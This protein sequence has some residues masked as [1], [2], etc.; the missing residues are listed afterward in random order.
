MPSPGPIGGSPAGLPSH[1]TVDLPAAGASG[2]PHISEVSTQSNPQ[3]ALRIPASA[4]ANADPAAK[5]SP[6]G[7]WLIPHSQA[8]QARPAP[9]GLLAGQTVVVVFNP[10]ARDGRIAGEMPAVK[11]ELEKAGARVYFKETVAEPE[12]RIEGIRR[13]ID[14]R[15]RSGR[16]ITVVPYGGDGTIGDVARALGTMPGA[17]DY[18][19]LALVDKGTAADLAKQVGAP[20][21]PAQLAA[22]IAKAIPLKITGSK[23]AG[24]AGRGMVGLHTVS[25]GVGGDLFHLQAHNK[26]QNPD[27]PA[28]RGLRSFLRLAPYVLRSP[29]DRYGLSFKT[30]ITPS[31]GKPS[32]TFHAAEAMI[33]SSRFIGGVAGIPGAW[34]SPQLIFL[35]H[36]PRGHLVLG[37]LIA[38]GLATK[39]LGLNLTGPSSKL[40]TLGR[41][42][43]IHL[44]P[45]SQVQVS[46][47]LPNTP[48]WQKY[49]K[50][51]GSVAFLHGLLRR[52]HGD[53][54]VMHEATPGKKFPL[55]MVVNG[56]LVNTQEARYEVEI[57]KGGRI[58]VLAHPRSLAIDTSANSLVLQ[59]NDAAEIV[60]TRLFDASQLN[61]LLRRHGIT[62]EKV[63][64]L[65]LAV[66]GERSRGQSWAR[67]S[68]SPPGYQDVQAFLEGKNPQG[69]VW[70]GHHESW[71]RHH[72]SYRKAFVERARMHGVPLLLGF[73]SYWAAEAGLKHLGIDFGGDRLLHFGAITYLTHAVQS[74]VAPLWE[75]ALNRRLR[76]PFDY[77]RMRTMRLAGINHRQWTLARHKNLGG[78][79]R[80]AW[81]SS[82]GSIGPGAHYS[83]G[84]KIFRGA[85]LPVRAG[86]NMGLGMVMAGAAQRIATGLVEES[87]D[88]SLLKQYAPTVAGFAGFAAPSITHIISPRA[89]RFLFQN[90]LARGLSAVSGAAFM[91]DL[92]FSSW[93]GLNYGALSTHETRMGLRVLDAR[94]HSG[95]LGAVSQGLSFIAPTLAAHLA[96][97][98]GLL[99]GKNDAY[100][101]LE[102]QDRQMGK[103]LLVSLNS[104]VPA[105]LNSVDWTWQ[106]G[107]GKRRELSR[108]DKMIADDLDYWMQAQDHFSLGALALT[109]RRRYSGHNFS[110]DEAKE[111]IAHILLARTQEQMMMARELNLPY[112]AELQT[113]FRADGTLIA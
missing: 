13:A 3:I 60:R 91:A 8:P 68:N 90:R 93:H 43:Q 33:T 32:T 35:P 85:L 66:A 56:D 46:W 26:A 71:K 63:P 77:A 44:Q 65:L 103:D 106:Q 55:P 27:N 78:A 11:A 95:D 57:P 59:K 62:P 17:K 100:R 28:H 74:N 108:L 15:L 10:A 61:P 2:A 67:F 73:G 84:L 80:G 22:F 31:A 86:F 34:G 96:S 87:P 30:T 102:K 76:V 42:H 12:A 45:G 39:L 101:K 41:N 25:A 14:V 37:E 72:S 109:L 49:M 99:G 107:L 6:R 92:A 83:R 75:A 53:A 16:I 36:G 52:L 111:K 48:A 81:L 18:V 40:F 82:A 23:V 47:G 9:Q 50:R 98:D 89:S 7:L 79:L 51:P 105:L 110:Q 112:T 97:H 58:S 5:L 4:P 24:E 64:E 29:F 70:E 19:R 113:H 94:Q 20:K 88:S 104:T 1:P 54:A 21:H 69:Q 38:R